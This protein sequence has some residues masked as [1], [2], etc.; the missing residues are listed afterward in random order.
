[1][2]KSY[3]IILTA[4]LLLGCSSGNVVLDNP[5]SETAT[6]TFDGGDSHE[7]AA[8]ER[9]SISLEPGSHQVAISVGDSAVADTSFDLKD[10]G[11]VHSGQSRYV[12]W[13][14]LYGLQ[15]DRATL[16]NERWADLDSIR[17]FG[18][19][20][21][22]EPEWVFIE[23]NWDYGLE[24]DFPESKTMYITEDFQI[25]SKVFRSQDMIT[26]YKTLVANPSGK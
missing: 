13:K 17:V 12:I 19:F 7:V 1:M 14:Q 16:L 8:G 24:E 15:N 25:E 20:T 6:F 10:G 23:S 18:D 2:K 21:I 5:G 11:I 9:T 26:Y 22:Y 3:L 4:L